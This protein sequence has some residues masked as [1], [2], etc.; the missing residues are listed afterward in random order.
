MQPDA[1]GSR[2][3][4]QNATLPASTEPAMSRTTSLLACIL[5]LACCGQALAQGGGG[6]RG[7]KD[8]DGAARQS[9]GPA[10]AAEAQARATDQAHMQLNQARAA[11][12]LAPAQNP[13]FDTYQDRVVELLADLSRGVPAPAASE[14]ALKQIDRRVD[15]LRNRL[16]ALEDISDAARKLYAALTPDQQAA[17]DRV[18]PGTLPALYTQTSPFRGDGATR[19]RYR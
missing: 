16:A 18:L 2:G 15:L 19:E 4:G 5:L 6:K 1:P 11:L 3:P 12:R 8:D 14:S 17:A 13:L 9:T 7:S 10:S